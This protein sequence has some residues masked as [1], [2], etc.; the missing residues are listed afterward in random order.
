MPTVEIRLTVPEGTNISVITE[1]TDVQTTSAEDV[2][3]YWLN[4]L[5]GNAR[6]IYWAAAR[7]EMDGGSGFTLD[8][9]ASNI[10]QT[11]E[12]VEAETVRS[13]HRTSGRTAKVWREENGTDEPIRLI[14]DNYKWDEA[15]GGMRT[16]YRLPP[17]VAEKVN[18]VAV[19]HAGTINNPPY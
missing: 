17:G 6:K 4:Y 13:F 16:L 12:S 15:H 14:E 1:G 11:T 7:I 8:D 5:S 9:I 19:E 2:E 3:R 18:A 10:S